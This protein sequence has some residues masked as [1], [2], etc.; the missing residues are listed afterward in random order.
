M[1]SDCSLEGNAGGDREAR[2]SG[3]ISRRDLDAVL[4]MR[5]ITVV[6]GDM[7]GALLSRRPA[8]GD[9]RVQKEALSAAPLEVALFHISRTNQC[10]PR[11]A[12]LEPWWLWM[13]LRLIEEDRRSMRGESAAACAVR[14]AKWNI[15]V[16]SPLLHCCIASPLLEW[17]NRSSK[18]CL[19]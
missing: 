5:D 18:R 2:A 6:G 16:R 17:D 19:T 9:R 14:G 3:A 1:C 4:C 15:K 12:A 7:P 10:R 11:E 13:W 8:R